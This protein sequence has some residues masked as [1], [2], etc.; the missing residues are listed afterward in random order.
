MAFGT[1]E[2]GRSRAPDATPTPAP[3]S[4]TGDMRRPSIW[5]NQASNDAASD[6]ARDEAREQ[7]KAQLQS[8]TGRMFQVL[9]KEILGAIVS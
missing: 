4:P 2:G 5:V 1:G 8:I 9:M 6:F 3:P 7:A